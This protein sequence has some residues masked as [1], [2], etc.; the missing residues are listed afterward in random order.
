MPKRSVTD[1]AS[2]SKKTQLLVINPNSGLLIAFGSTNPND[3]MSAVA[4]TSGYNGGLDHGR[5]PVWVN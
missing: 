3:V 4:S 1:A 2:T 5:R